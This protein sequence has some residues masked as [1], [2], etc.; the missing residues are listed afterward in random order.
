MSQSSRFSYAR[1]S[2]PD[3]LVVGGRELNG[4]LVLLD[5]DVG[6]DGDGLITFVREVDRFDVIA[7][8]SSRQEQ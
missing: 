1:A 2:L 6:R 4:L 5:G 3:D 7:T 8:A